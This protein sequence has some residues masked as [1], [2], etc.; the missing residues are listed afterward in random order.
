MIWA[1]GE[2]AYCNST[3]VT[4]YSTKYLIWVPFTDRM[5]DRMRPTLVK[6]SSGF[7][8][9][10]NHHRTRTPCGTRVRTLLEQ[11]TM[12]YYGIGWY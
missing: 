9:Y 3:Q 10:P 6:I 8:L 2:L 5:I 7:S 11:H 4:E 12:A 1:V